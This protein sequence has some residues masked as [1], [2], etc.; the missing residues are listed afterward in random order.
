MLVTQAHL[1][2]HLP[3]HC[4]RVVCLDTDGVELARHSAEN[5][6]RAATPRNLAYVMYTS[7]STGVP[8]GVMIPHRSL[9]SYMTAASSRYGLAAGDRVLQFASIS[10]DASAEEI[11]PCLIRGATLVLRTDAM[12]STSATFLRHCRTWDLTV[13]N[14][15]TAYWHA[16]SADMAT[17][18]LPFPA[19]VRFV[20]IGGE[21]ALT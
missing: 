17:E 11:Y 18:A 8:K 9:V 3:P 4:A 7:G 6:R 10:F 16:L 14:L 13:L 21:Q 1:R 12:V 20:I 5:L 2:A 15:P 19:S